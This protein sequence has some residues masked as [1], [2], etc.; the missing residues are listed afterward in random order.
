MDGWD[1]FWM[2]FAMA[3]W[4]VVLASVVYAA[5]KLANRPPTDRPQR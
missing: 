1:W 5:V 4:A 3:F 2:S